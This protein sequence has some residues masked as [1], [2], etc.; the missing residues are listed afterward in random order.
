MARSSPASQTAWAVMWRGTSRARWPSPWRPKSPP[1]PTLMIADRVLAANQA[2]RDRVSDEP[3]LA[4]MGTTM[5]LGL[6]SEDGSATIGHVGDSRCYLLRDGELERVTSD[7]TVV[8]ELVALGHIR[9]RMSTPIRSATSSPG[10]SGSAPS[11]STPNSLDL[12]AGDRAALLLRRPHVDAQRPRDQGH[13][14][15]RE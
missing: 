14:R 8:A 6:F 5:T 7:H 4:G 9:T 1:T 11:R 3:N 13:P 15:L 10:H 2:I 12:E